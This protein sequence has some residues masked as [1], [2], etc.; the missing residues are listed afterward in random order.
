MFWYRGKGGQVAA[1]GV[2]AL[3]LQAG[4]LASAQQPVPDSMVDCC[5]VL[6]DF[7]VAAPHS[8]EQLAH[9]SWPE[10]EQLYRQAGVEAVPQGYVRGRAIYCSDQKLSGA[11]SAVTH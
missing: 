6:A 8:L 10:L 5:P 2:L 3:I 9:L 1:L 4:G 11:R 7:P